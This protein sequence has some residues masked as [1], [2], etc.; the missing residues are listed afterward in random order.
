MSLSSNMK[1]SPN[2]VQPNIFEAMQKSAHNSTFIQ[3]NAPENGENS[4]YQSFNNQE[5]QPLS[6]VS[7][8]S[9]II[10]GYQ[11]GTDAGKE[12]HLGKRHLPKKLSMTIA[13]D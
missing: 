3:F 11:G 12:S 4:L 6:Q 9:V 2:L 10:S 13:K 8:N 7:N 1:A 5:E